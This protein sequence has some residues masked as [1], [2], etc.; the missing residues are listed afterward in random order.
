[1]LSRPGQ[2]ITPYRKKTSL[3]MARAVLGGLSPVHYWDFIANRALFNSLDVGA[4]A[5]TPN[6]T[7]TRASAGY[8]NQTPNAEFG[9]QNLALWSQDWSVSPWIN[10]IGGT[11][12][13]NAG[14]APDGT[15]TATRFTFSTQFS[16]RAQNITTTDGV[17]YV[18][19]FW[20]KRESGNASLTFYHDQ[21]A[22]GNF[23]AT[24]FTI[25]DSWARY[26][27]TCLGRSGSG[28]VV[29][30]IQDRNASGQGSILVWGAQFEPGSTATTYKPTTSSAVTDVSGPPL[31]SFG[32]GVPRL[33]NKGVLIEGSA[34]NLCLQS[35]T[36][37]DATW[38]KSGTTPAS[39][40]ANSIAAPDG[41]TTADTI[42]GSG[43]V[44]DR[45]Q[46]SITLANSTSYT[47]SMYVKNIDALATR[48]NAAVVSGAISWDF[49]W[50]GAILT[51]VTNTGGVGTPNYVAVGGGWYRLYGTFTTAGAGD[52]VST[53]FRLYP[54]AASTPKSVY[55]WGAQIEASSYPTSYIVTTTVSA[56]RAA[57]VINVTGLSQSGPYSL[58]AEVNIDNLS[59]SG[60]VFFGGSDG[61]ANNGCALYQAAGSYIVLN[62]TGGSNDAVVVP[63]G[64]ATVG[65]IIKA[66]GRI[67]TN[68]INGRVN[69]GALGTVDTACTAQTLSQLEFGRTNVNGPPLFGYIRRAAIFNTALTDTQLQ[70]ITT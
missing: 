33:T 67:E 38:T 13:A 51:S 2:L 9:S 5:A 60:N 29:A 59:S 70:T 44:A 48:M 47:Y 26:S 62:R 54:E 53:A 46:Q 22:S 23:N 52:N 45:V 15:N 41:T 69:G 24:P 37:D 56:T 34:V 39:V 57:D 14:T 66:A 1:M 55:A 36:F 19:S 27:V 17:T 4:V 30:G 50:S 49:N 63:A 12:T 31:V 43:A 20:A 11:S 64:T 32:S 7:F 61:T 16:V 65:A 6:W 58:Y 8:A 28:L 3:D 42:T 68:N 10:V 40:V 18:W 21:S 25:T 35:Q